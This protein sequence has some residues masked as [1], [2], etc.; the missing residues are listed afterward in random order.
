M[1]CCRPIPYNG[2]DGLQETVDRR[3]GDKMRSLA[4]AIILLAWTSPGFATAPGPLKVFILAGQSNMEGQAVADLDGKDYNGGKGTLTHL[5]NDP[6]R[7]ALARHLRS[8][9]GEWAVR[10]DVW[11]R[12][13]PE[14]GPVK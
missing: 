10:Q 4:A 11:V 9:K 14:S 6:D 2:W 5:L 13:Q 3:Q 1:T 7:A 12:Y 8:G